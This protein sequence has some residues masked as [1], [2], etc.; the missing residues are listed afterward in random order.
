M[1]VLNG[2]VTSWL[3]SGLAGWSNCVFVAKG[4]NDSVG[5]GTVLAPYLTVQ[6]GIDACTTARNKLVIGAGTFSEPLTWPTDVSGIEMIG[7]GA[8]GETV[9][10]GSLDQAALHGILAKIRD[11]G[12]VLSAVNRSMQGEP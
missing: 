2:N 11:L 7:A 12:L 1:P 9:L 3:M 6:V 5:D 8:N 4:G 10:S